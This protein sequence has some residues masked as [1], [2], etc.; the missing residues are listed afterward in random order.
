MSAQNHSKYYKANGKLLITAEY[1]VLDGAKALAVPCKY[2]QEM[3]ISP[4]E[5]EGI[6]WESKDENNNIWFYCH[7]TQNIEISICSDYSIAETLKDI[8]LSGIQYSENIDFNNVYIETKVNFNRNFGLGTSSTLI[9]L[10]AQ[11]LHVD[12]YL[13]LEKSFGGSGYDIACATSKKAIT[14]QITNSNERAINEVFFQPEF[15]QN[16]F[17]VYLEKKQNSRSGIEHYRKLAIQEKHKIIEQINNITEKIIYTNN[18]EEFN[19]LIAEHETIISNQLQ[20]Q[21]IKEQLFSDFEGSIKSLGAWG[22]DFVM[23]CSANGEKY[24]Q[25]YFKEKKYNNI[26]SFTQMIQD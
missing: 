13:L 4:S 12:P 18:I 7:F 11:W 26:I 10:I 8:I 23:V 6:Y 14:Y 3:H 22:G 25:H 15:K 2:Y 21:P 16:I 19:H 1:F 24:I 9:S 5:K 17:F 20:I